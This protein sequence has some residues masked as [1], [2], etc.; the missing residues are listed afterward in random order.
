MSIQISI[1][2]DEIYQATKYICQNSKQYYRTLPSKCFQLSQ[3][4]K[5]Y[6]PS[7]ISLKIKEDDNHNCSV[8][9]DIAI[10]LETAEEDN[11]EKKS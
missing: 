3:F 2:C 6:V 7:V 9:P 1:N 4:L 11:K 10:D 5:Q 8:V